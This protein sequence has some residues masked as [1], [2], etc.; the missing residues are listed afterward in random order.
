MKRLPMRVLFLKIKRCIIIFLDMMKV[1]EAS[2]KK[3]VCKA[4]IIRR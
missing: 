3:C 4:F 1:L 2:A